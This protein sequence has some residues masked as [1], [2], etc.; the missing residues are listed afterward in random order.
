M[1]V[2]VGRFLADEILDLGAQHRVRQ[3]ILGHVAHCV[4][5]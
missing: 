4:D 5:E 2:A 3:A 1:Q